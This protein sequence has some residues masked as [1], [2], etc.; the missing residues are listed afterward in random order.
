MVSSLQACKSA[1]YCSKDVKST[2]EAMS[3]KRECV[4]TVTPELEPLSTWPMPYHLFTVSTHC[5][6]NM[7]PYISTSCPMGGSLQ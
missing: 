1:K 2:I 3:H 6:T 5:F 7:L 4:R